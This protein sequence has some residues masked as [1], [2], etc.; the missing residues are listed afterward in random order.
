M[1]ADHPSISHSLE[2]ISY[3]QRHDV[4]LG[5]STRWVLILHLNIT[6]I[7]LRTGYSLINIRINILIKLC[8]ESHCAQRKMQSSGASLMAVYTR[9]VHLWLFSGSRYLLLN[10]HTHTYRLVGVSLEIHL[11]G[12]KWICTVNINVC[13]P[14]LYRWECLQLMEP[15]SVGWRWKISQRKVNSSMKLFMQWTFSEGQRRGDT[16]L[17]TRCLLVFN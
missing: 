4:C 12:T 16:L 10:T 13:P 14:Y 3:T 1:E 17:C 7:D 9:W 8:T 5:S 6:D 15:P 2:V 11:Q